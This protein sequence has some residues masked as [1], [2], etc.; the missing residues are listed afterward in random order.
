MPSI[1]NAA[2]SVPLPTA[3]SMTPQQRAGEQVYIAEGCV[4]CHTQQVRSVEMDKMWGERPGMAADYAFA[5]RQDV[6]RNPATLMGTERTGP[7]LTNVGR[8]QPSEE[9]HY[10]HLNAPRSVVPGSVMPSYPWLFE[11]RNGKPVPTQKARDLVAYLL[12]RKQASLPNGDA[13]TVA[14]STNISG[15][16]LYTTYCGACHQADGKGLPG[17]FP[18]LAQSTIVTGDDLDRYVDIIMNGVDRSPEYA[19]MPPIGTMNNL[20]P[21]QV[22][23]IINHERTSF[24]NAAHKVSIDEIRS[25]LQRMR[26]QP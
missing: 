26:S 7:D 9:W 24:G 16:D 3:D 11:H 25:S 2:N 8:R 20:T 12:S 1:D 14:A 6:W 21:E 18:P 22:A 13:S 15:A 17:A 19:V 23:A 5:T 10:L 4:A